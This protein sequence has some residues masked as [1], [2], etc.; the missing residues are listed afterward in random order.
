MIREI[1]TALSRGINMK[2]VM[3]TGSEGQVGQYLTK[4]LFSLG[5]EVV[6]FD[7][8][9]GNDIRKYEDVRNFVDKH[10]PDGIFHL[11]AQAYVP[12]SS[13]NSVR[14]VEVNVIGTLNVLN[15]V[16]ETGHSSYVHI[17]GTSEEYG[18]DRDDVFL[19]ENSLCQPTT[20]YGVTKLAATNLGLVYARMYGMNVVCTRAWNH[21]G[22]G[23]SSIYA[24]SAFAK[25]VAIAEKYN[26]PVTHGNLEAI[27]NYTDVRDIVEAY[28]MLIGKSGLY[29]LA[30]PR[31]ASIK[32]VLELLM[33]M[34][35]AKIVLDGNPNLFR[36]QSN[37]FPTP[38]TKKVFEE[39]GWA[40]KIT[41]ETTLEETLNYWRE[42]V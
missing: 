26:K 22:P 33:G 13:L 2:K 39:L 23:T 35:K 3:V 6:K 18:Y 11:A 40:A 29:N 37:K 1:L 27:R 30:S 17:A 12:E 34:S 14:G 8:R 32:E 4:A 16:R 10:S 36:A 20:P 28:I 31:N 38:S 5:V 21:F 19:D 7:I 24:T 9:L 41:L 25:R 42:N 15:A